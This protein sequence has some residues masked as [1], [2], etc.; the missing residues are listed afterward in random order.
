MKIP[1]S[2]LKQIIQEEYDKFDSTDESSKDMM[3][4]HVREVKDIIGVVQVFD[5]RIVQPDTDLWN[6]MRRL[7]VNVIDQYTDFEGDGREPGEREAKYGR[8]TP[9]DARREIMD[10]I[11]AI[12]Y[13]SLEDFEIYV[14]EPLVN[15]T[16]PEE[17]GSETEDEGDYATL[18]T[19][20]AESHGR[21]KRVARGEDD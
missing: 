21:M 18:K 2:L 12:F 6:A 16:F 3:D 8:M 15:E 1:K 20:D 10:S 13:N 11:N 5:D 4:P 17:E 9:D 14:A 19:P 7:A